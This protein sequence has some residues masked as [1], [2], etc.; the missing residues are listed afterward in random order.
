MRRKPETIWE[1]LRAWWDGDE[2]EG[3][4]EQAQDPTLA[5]HLLFGIPFLIALLSALRRMTGL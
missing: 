5:F 3:E 2:D 1:E 4:G